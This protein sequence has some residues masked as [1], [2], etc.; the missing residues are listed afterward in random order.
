MDTWDQVPY[1]FWRVWKWEQHLVGIIETPWSTCLCTDQ[2]WCKRSHT[3]RR[4]SGGMQLSKAFFTSLCYILFKNVTL[5]VQSFPNSE[6]EGDISPQK[7]RQQ[8]IF[9]TLGTW[10]SFGS[11]WPDGKP[12]ALGAEVI[13]HALWLSVPPNSSLNTSVSGEGEIPASVYIALGFASNLVRRDVQENSQRPR[14]LHVCRVSLQ[15]VKLSAS[16]N[17]N[18]FVKAPCNTWGQLLCA[19]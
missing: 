16:Q 11:R 14:L 7:G 9:P 8:S 3:F 4:V 15:N 2:E 17:I 6:S 1:K 12:A 10:C 18:V 19:V 5:N 13:I